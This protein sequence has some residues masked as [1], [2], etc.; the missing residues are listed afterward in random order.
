M[1]LFAVFG[2]P[3]L[4]SRSPQ[5]WNAAFNARGIDAHY[6]RINPL[7]AEHA[8][9][10][11]REIP[12]DGC[13]VT[14]PYKDELFASLD[15]CDDSVAQLHAV[16]TI[17]Y[18]NRRLRGWNTDMYGVVNSLREDGIQFH[19]KKIV[20]LGAG[21][22]ARAA[23]YGLLKANAGEIV[24]LNR[25]YEK[26]VA[27]AEQLGCRA[28]Y[29]SR[30]KTELQDADVL[31]SCIPANKRIIKPEWLHPGLAVLDANYA[32]H[33]LL[34]EDA[35]AVGCHIISGLNWLVH[36]AVPAFEHLLGVAPEQDMKMTMQQLFANPSSRLHAKSIS[37][38]GFMGT[39]KTTVGKAFAE[40]TGKEFID[41]DALIEQ[42]AGMTIPDIFQQHGEA[43]FRSIERTVFDALDF[44][45]EKI[46]S[47]GGGA[48]VNEENRRCLTANTTVIWL[49]TELHALLNRMDTTNRPL[50]HVDDVEAKARELLTR[51]IPIYAQA[52]D[53]MIVNEKISAASLAKK[54]Y[55]EIYPTSGD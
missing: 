25:T 3:I 41:T 37:F 50:F 18:E 40:L 28:A 27:V 48:V 6:F 5:L 16:N 2:N 47:C 8:A 22:A 49:W 52:A 38:I 33:S 12:L 35:N 42:R 14:T 19:G 20:I 11:I 44:S 29:A 43:H 39:G 30:S 36:Q 24:L 31:I 15:E 23:V 4:H 26:A 13:N 51:R 46:I 54:I 21:G 10:L 9:R 32:S 55:G 7:D 34:L 53:M 17:K 45:T 1:K